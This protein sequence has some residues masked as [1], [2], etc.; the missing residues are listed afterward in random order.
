MFGFV[1]AT[2]Y[3]IGV[4]SALWFVVLTSNEITVKDIVITLIAGFAGPAMLLWV[5]GELDIADKVIWKKKDE[6]CD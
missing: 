6:D 5:F 4:L 1:I 3:I 2:W